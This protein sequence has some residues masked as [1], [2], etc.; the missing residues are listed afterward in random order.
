MRQWRCVSVSRVVTLTESNICAGVGHAF[1]NRY[2]DFA[3]EKRKGAPAVLETH[4][5]DG[6]MATETHHNGKMIQGL[7]VCV[8]CRDGPAAAGR[9]REHP[10]HCMAAHP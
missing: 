9:P 5:S 1:M 8:H 2:T 6:V 3:K 10:G 4:M 7:A